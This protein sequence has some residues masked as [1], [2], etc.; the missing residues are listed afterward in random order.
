M[1]LT[2]TLS[3]T[4]H[5]AARL[6][7][8]VDACVAQ[9]IHVQLA[10]DHKLGVG[11]QQHLVLFGE[12]GV[13]PDVSPGLDLDLEDHAHALVDKRPHSFE[14]AGR[15]REGR[16]LH[17]PPLWVL[18]PHRRLVEACVAAPIPVDRQIERERWT[19]VERVLNTNYRIRTF[20]PSW[21]C[22]PQSFSARRNDGCMYV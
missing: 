12:V 10:R 7:G 8:K 13:G 14:T 5:R 21:L 6:F 11:R 3:R 15:G 1:L 2:D 20:Y 19:V 4:Q 22:V 16:P 17:Q 9:L 18:L